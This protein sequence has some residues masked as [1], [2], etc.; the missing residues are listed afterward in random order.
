MKTESTYF[1]YRRQKLFEQFKPLRIDAF[2]VTF[3]PHLRYISGFSGS[4]GIGVVTENN[5]YLITDGR[6]ASQV[7]SETEDW[8]IIITTK[9]LFQEIK[10][11]KLLRNGMRVGFDGNTMFFSQFQQLKNLFPKVK[12]LPKVDVIN[13]IV[14]VKDETEIEKIKKAVEITDKVFTDILS[15]IKPDVREID[16]AAEISYRHMKYGAE[17]DGFPSIVA[18]GER[19]AL[20]HGRASEK[21]LKYG[22]LVTLD[23]GCMYNGYHSDMTRTVVIGKPKSEAKK[24]YNIV[25]EAQ[26]KAIDSAHAGMKAKELDAIARSYIK[27]K[28]YEKYFKHS[29]GHGIGLQIHE[30]PRLSV[31]S[32][33]ILEAGNVLTIEPGI[34]IPGFGGV[35]IEDDIVITNGYCDI[36]N[37]SPKEL[38]IL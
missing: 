21:K 24:I 31:L 33:A 1:K 26:Q 35:R 19:S 37:T 6:Y 13:K 11:K 29:L 10:T 30:Q 38:L 32:N 3:Q 5:Y 28:G 7:K 36:L 17:G 8:K 25:L 14:A 34:Y 2:L 27:S 18:S 9:D 22:D 20:P 12:F 16:I 4:A 23:F 15:F